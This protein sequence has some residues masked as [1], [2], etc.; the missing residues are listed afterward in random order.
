MHHKIY[1]KSITYL[2]LVIHKLVSLI[3]DLKETTL[4]DFIF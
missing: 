3:S 2:E 1:K 4:N